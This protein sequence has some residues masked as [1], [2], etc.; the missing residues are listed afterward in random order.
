MTT[1]TTGPAALPA[2]A[3][4]QTAEGYRVAEVNGNIQVWHG[5]G[6]IALLLPAA[7]LAARVNDVIERRRRMLKEIEEKTGWKPEPVQIP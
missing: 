4:E 6:Q 1:A 3:P 7:D 5:K 2:L